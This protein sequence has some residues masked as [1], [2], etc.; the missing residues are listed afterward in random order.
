MCSCIVSYIVAEVIE[1]SR[2]AYKVAF[3]YAKEKMEPT[4]PIR[5]GLAL[6]FSVFHYEIMNE[7]EEACKM[8]K[9]V[10]NHNLYLKFRLFGGTSV[11]TF[12]SS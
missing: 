4:H 7:R 1:K 3:E 9:G 12:H 10:S 2:K 6:N 8:A 11:T 5:L